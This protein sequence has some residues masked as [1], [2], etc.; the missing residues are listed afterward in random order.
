MNCRLASIWAAISPTAALLL[1][2]CPQ[3]LDDG[4]N[5]T[6]SPAA[7]LDAIGG[8]TLDAELDAGILGDV[9]APPDAAASVLSHVPGSVPADGARGVLPK[10]P[11]QLSF[12]APM[13]RRSVETAY[14]S[15]DLP[16]SDVTFTWSDGDTVLHLQPKAPLRSSAGS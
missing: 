15:S 12:S 2:A 5:L 1:L 14:S 4:F 10:S 6:S 8:L 9:V 3:V 7:G 11:L 16:A 13:D